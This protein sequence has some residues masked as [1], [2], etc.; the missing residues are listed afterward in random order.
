MTHPAPQ[1]AGVAVAGV[2]DRVQP[3]GGAVGQGGLPPDAEQGPGQPALPLRH[4]PQA[5]GGGAGEQPHQHG[6]GLVVGG[7]PQGDGA[8]ADAVGDLGEPPVAGAASL[9]LKG[10]ARRHV[11]PDRLEAEPQPARQGGH[12]GRLGRRSRPQPM[13]DVDHVEPP[14]PAGAPAGPGHP[15]ARSSPVP[16]CRPPRPS[17]PAG[18]RLGDRRRRRPRGG[19]GR[20]RRPARGGQAGRPAWRYLDSN[21]GHTGYEPGA[22]PPE[23]YRRRE[24]RGPGRA[25]APT[26]APGGG[27]V[28]A[29]GFE[30]ATFGL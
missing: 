29:A 25:P 23:L 14:A 30:P 26:P 24:R 19:P 12:R 27:V 8:G 16:R 18:G 9:V 15:P 13:V 2:V 10:G 11:D 28:A 22:L 21:Q 6:L 1:E 3:Q 17:P 20:P 5:P 4:R 7:V